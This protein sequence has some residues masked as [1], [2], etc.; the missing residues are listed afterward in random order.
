VRIIEYTFGRPGTSG[1]G[2]KHRFAD[3]A[4]DAG[5]HPAK[6]L[7]SCCT[8]NGGRKSL[9]LMS[10]RPINESGRCYGS[11]TPAGVVQRFTACSWATTVDSQADV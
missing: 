7:K 5:R 3:D 11:E 1:S 6:R 8:M 9:P 2:E 10:S 4:V